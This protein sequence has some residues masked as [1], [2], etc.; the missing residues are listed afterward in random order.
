MKSRWVPPYTLSET[1]T[2]W[3]ALT[4]VS[5]AWV[6][7]MPDAKQY[8]STPPSS[9]ARFFSSERRVRLWVRAYS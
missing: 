6:A 1:T 3:P 8:A 2:R 5:T 7:A 9:A 4:R